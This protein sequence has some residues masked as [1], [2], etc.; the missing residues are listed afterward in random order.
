MKTRFSFEKCALML[1]C[2]LIPL[3]GWSLSIDAALSLPDGRAA[4]D[5]PQ[6]VLVSFDDYVD[7][8]VEE[9]V[10]RVFDGRSNSNGSPA[11]ATFFVMTYDSDFWQINNLY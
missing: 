7:D 2:A 5:A 10:G 11:Q 1:L 6:M 8:E 9:L 4:G 3:G